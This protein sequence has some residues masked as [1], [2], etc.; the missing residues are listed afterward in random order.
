MAPPRIEQL[1]YTQLA[2]EFSVI[3]MA[4]FYESGS[5][6]LIALGFQELHSKSK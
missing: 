5:M 6:R 3:E 2:S 1:I 4:D